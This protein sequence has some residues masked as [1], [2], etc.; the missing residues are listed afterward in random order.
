MNLLRD[1]YTWK[2]VQKSV[3]LILERKC[4]CVCGNIAV[5]YSCEIVPNLLLSLKVFPRLELLSK[6]SEKSL[7]NP[8]N[9]L[10]T[11]CFISFPTFD[12]LMWWFFFQFIW[13]LYFWRLTN[14]INV[15]FGTN[16]CLSCNFNIHT[17]WNLIS[18]IFY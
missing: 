17:R 12:T 14:K 3:R 8:L 1:C 6:V 5:F 2:V 16:V 7:E 10:L 15:E 18:N 11:Q 13:C 4:V 9:F